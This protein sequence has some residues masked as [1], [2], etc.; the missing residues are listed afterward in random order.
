[1][2]ASGPPTAPISQ[3]SALTIIFLIVLCDMMGFGLIIP[4]LPLYAKKFSASPIQVALLFALFSLCQ[5]VASPIL[6]ALSDRYGRRP[7]LLLSLFG[8][9]AGYVLLGWTMLHEWHNATLALWMMYLARIIDGVSGGNIST[10]QAY[11][12]DVTPPESRAAAM[13][14]M[15]AAF[16]LGF[17]AGPAIGG[18]LSFWHES[19]PAFAAAGFALLAM[20]ATIWRLP[21]SRVH[22]SDETTQSWLHPGRF[23]PVLGNSIVMCMIGIGSITMISYVMMEVVFALFLNQVFGYGQSAVNWFFATA[24]I[25]V[26]VTQAGL[27]GRLTRRFGE[28]RL[29]LAGPFIGTAAMACFAASPYI[30]FVGALIVATFLN[31]VGRSLQFPSISALISRN[32]G[33]QVQGAAFGLY[34]GLSSLARVIGPL[35]AGALF[36]KHPTAPF[37]LGGT[38][39]LAMAIWT[40]TLRRRAAEQRAFPV[41][42]AAESA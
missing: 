29:A 27:I 14:L 11:I 10:A 22:K 35:I 38:I 42:A 37:L 31:A 20:I 36:A 12:G 16:G 26:M 28:W 33:Q 17:S 8:T 2:S 34:M 32:V 40:T 3:R 24:G 23:K 6:G 5:F 4:S 1:M 13:G 15:G 41:I 30:P 19:A 9:V 25:T 7:V 21:E 39:T 18:L